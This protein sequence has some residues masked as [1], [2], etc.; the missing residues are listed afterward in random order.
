MT[1]VLDLKHPSPREP[2]EPESVQ[3]MAIT[4]TESEPGALVP[5]EGPGWDNEN[6]EWEAHHALPNSARRRNRM[7]MAGL[8]ALGGVVALW[9]SSWMVLVAVA[10]GLAAWEAH[11]RTARPFPVRLGPRG[12]TVGDTHIPHARLGS[13][14]VHRMPDGAH[15]LSLRTDR[16]FQ[17]Y[18]RVPLG[19][20]D[21]DA[22]RAFL[23]ANVVEEQHPVPLLE[24]WMRQG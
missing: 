15:E 5:D 8:A 3:A 21:P 18:L 1:N 6:I 14:D 10:S 2:E 9:Q 20:A 7:A 19:D 23:A 17:R 24:W 13:F 22:V 12:L 11:E 16:W 4:A